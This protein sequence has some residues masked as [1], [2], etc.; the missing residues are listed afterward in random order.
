MD[1][2]RRVFFGC[3]TGL[4][5]AITIARVANAEDQQSSVAAYVPS[6]RTQELLSLFDL[7]YPIL[8][9]PG[10]F[11]GPDLAIAVCSVGAMGS[12][13]VARLHELRPRRHSHRPRR[14]DL[15]WRHN[16]GP[17]RAA[18]GKGPPGRY[19]RPREQA[20]VRLALE[21]S[22]IRSVLREGRETGESGQ[23]PLRPHHRY[24][25]RSTESAGMQ[26]PNRSGRDGLGIRPI[27][28]ARL[29]ALHL[30]AK[31]ARRGLWSD[32]HPTPPWEWRRLRALAVT[33]LRRAP[34]FP[35]LPTIDESGFPGFEYALWSGLLAPA[36]TPSMIVRKLHLETVRAPALSDLRA[37]LADLGQ[38]GIGNSPD[39]FATLIKSEIPRWAKVIREAEIKP[40]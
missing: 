24:G 23:R 11:A 12:I 3:A 26:T 33:S 4:A 39:E 9:A 10:G 36:W 20:G 38:E 25:L 32:P 31:A 40:D 16:H 19:R 18:T 1:N 27:R 13:G 5:A 22:A 7:S 37:K 30:Q 8:Q 6:Q 34:R 29:P 14:R 35:E 21:A 15:R 17:G 28:Q 2:S